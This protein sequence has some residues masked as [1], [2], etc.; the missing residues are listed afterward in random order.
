V[1]EKVIM[2]YYECELHTARHF[3]MTHESL[4]L[5]Q[6]ILAKAGVELVLNKMKKGEF[7]I[8]QAHRVLEVF[9]A[10]HEVRS[11]VAERQLPSGCHRKPHCEVCGN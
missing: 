4:P 3:Y 9:T 6:L 7:L 8:D 10:V 5:M 1:P 11:Q 2:D